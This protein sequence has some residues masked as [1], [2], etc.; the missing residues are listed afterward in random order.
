M[1]TQEDDVD[2]HALHRQGWTISAIARH[3]GHDRKTIR[4]NLKGGRVAGRRQQH[5]GPVQP[6]RGLLRAAAERRP[7]LV[8]PRRRLTRSSGWA[9]T[10][11]MPASPA[12]CGRTGSGRTASRAASVGSAP[13]ATN[14]WSLTNSSTPTTM[15][16]RHKAGRTLP[17]SIPVRFTVT[18][19]SS[20]S[21]AT[22]DRDTKPFP[23]ALTL[24][25][26]DHR[27]LFTYGV[28][29][30]CVVFLD[31]QSPS[32]PTGQALP[33][34]QPPCRIIPRERSRLVPLKFVEP[35]SLR[36]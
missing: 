29:P 25:R 7:A 9:S 22:S 5:P 3:L 15:T 34:V 20:R 33:C 4:A 16:S 28:V 36:D 13:A 1:L 32:S 12:T 14:P 10:V 30:S 26:L 8:G 31:L 2:A 24:T 23:V 27:L 19:V 35:G 6:V 18:S 11:L 21:S 17:P